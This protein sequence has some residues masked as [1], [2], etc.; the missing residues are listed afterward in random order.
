MCEQV[1][2]HSRSRSQ[3]HGSLTASLL[4]CHA[5]SLV[6]LE[7]DTFSALFLETQASLVARE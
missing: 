3:R 6:S 1:M 2:E 4:W 7:G 5:H